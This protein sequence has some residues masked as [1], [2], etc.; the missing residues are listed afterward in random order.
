MQPELSPT[1]R[2]LLAVK[3]LR[4][5][6]AAAES[7]AKEPIAIIGMACRFPG[8]ATT[9]AAFWDLLAAGTD[10]VTE[11][12]AER[13][14]VDAF[15]DPEPGTAGKMYTRYGAFLQHIDQF[16]PHVFNIAPR[17]VA[18]MDPQHRLLLETAWEAL[19][20]SGYPPDGLASTPAGVFVGAGAAEY[21]QIGAADPTRIDPYLTLGST[22]SAAAGRISYVLGLQGPSMLVDTACSSSL[23]AVH[24]ACASLRAGDCA[25]AIAGAVNLM[26]SPNSTIALSSL[27]MMAPDGRCKTFDAA[28]DGFVRGE[29]CGIVVL[30]RLTQALRDGDRVLAVIRGSA[31]NQD[32]RSGGFTAPNGLAQQALIRRALANASVMP[33]EVSYVECHGTGTSLGDPVELHALSAVLG[34]GRPAERPLLVG[35]V[36]T[37]VGHL[38]AAAGMAGLIKTVLALGHRQIT[39]HLHLKTPNPYIA[40]SS[41]PVAV[42]R[43]LMAWE[44]AKLRIAGVSSFGATGTNA[45]VIV[46]EAPAVQ[47]CR[48]VPDR[49]VHILT[50][51]GKSEAALSASRSRM[52]EHLAA[53]ID[54]FADICHT[55]STGRSHFAHRI[56]VTAADAAQACEKLAAAT[57]AHRTAAPRIAFLF[58]G[59]GS[60]Y[61]GMGR[62]LGDIDLPDPEQTRY[63]QPAL[64]KLEYRLAQLWRSWGI[65]PAF[66]LGHSVGEYAAAAVAGLFSYEEGLRLITRRAELM[67]NLPAGGAMLAV[68]CSE[69]QAAEFLSARVSLAAVNGPRSIVLSGDADALDRVHFQCERLKVSHA[70]HSSRMDPILP[71]LENAVAGVAFQASRIPLVSNLTGRVATDGELSAPAYWSRHARHTV[72]FMD[73]IQTLQAEGCE[74]YIEIGP[75]PVLLGMA[76]AQLDEAALALPSLRRNRDDWEQLLESLAALYTAGASVDW[77]AFDAPY[78]R[79]R[80]SLPTYPFQ[81]QRYWLD[82]AP[83][84]ANAAGGRPLLGRSLRSPELQSQVFETEWS[85]ASPAFLAEH[86]LFGEAVAPAAAWLAMIAAAGHRCMGNVLLHQPL[87]LPERGWTQVQT[88]LKQQGFEIYSSVGDSWTLHASGNFAESQ[89]PPHTTLAEAQAACGLPVDTAPHYETLRAAGIELGPGFRQIAELSRGPG[90]AVGR[91][92]PQHELH[93]GVIDACLQML[94]A[95]A[96]DSLTADSLFAP[97]AIE[98][99]E[100]PAVAPSWCCALLRPS[101]ANEIA[102]DLTLFGEDGAPVGFIEGLRL[103]RASRTAFLRA[104]G[105]LYEIAWK[106]AGAG[107]PA[108]AS[109]RKFDQALLQSLQSRPPAGHL[110]LIASTLEDAPLRGLAATLSLEYPD[111]RT[112]CIDTDDPAAPAFHVSAGEDRI[113]I[114]NRQAF[115]PRLARLS[116]R[117]AKAPPISPD[118]TYLITGG[119]GA[120]GLHT[121]RWLVRHG[122]RHLVLTGRRASASL[123]EFDGLD[124]RYVSADV[125]NAADVSRLFAEIAAT[126][127]PLRGILH[128]AGLLD[129][130]VLAQQTW[131]RFLRVM[132]PKVAGSWNLHEASQGLPLDFFVLYSSLAGLLGSPG[133]ANYAAAN[134]YMDALAHHRRELG[135]PALSINWGPWAEAGMAAGA[136]TGRRLRTAG[137]RA[138]PP[139]A[140]LAALELALSRDLAQVVIVDADWSAMRSRKTPAILADL[141][142]AESTPAAEGAF[143]RQLRDAN[144]ARRTGLLRDYVRA[145]VARV[146]GRDAVFTDTEKFFELGMDSL[147]ALELKNVLQTDLAHRMP[148]TLSFEYPTVASLCVFLS[149]VLELDPP[150]AATAAPSDDPMLAQLEELSEDEAQALLDAKLQA[151]DALEWETRN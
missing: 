87:V 97:V 146:L 114:R 138:M 34:E 38:E 75:H 103:R 5:K 26:L 93:T 61:A 89:S 118:A 137:L 15:Y 18:G 102:G 23:V 107:E 56:A 43:E 143:L 55:A 68:Q 88:V 91:V 4:A 98:R 69:T 13:W 149:G 81:R 31:V 124:V 57:A 17:E 14:D 44:S 133:Q 1:Q 27:R 51:S 21:S 122:A 28:A 96:P 49:P 35:S 136:A 72:R 150:P 115:V 84:R 108:A 148:S 46:E 42:P 111:L 16:D 63:V 66:V 145:Q 12:P 29:G 30:K 22:P 3:D 85:A 78:Q 64:Y 117:P 104:A 94:G 127:P 130:G 67:Q 52:L 119:L 54:S 8:G 86:R 95:A 132:A 139:E 39:P 110:C 65:E 40:W 60:Q 99:L 140:A 2:A 47:D 100:L 7:A 59:Q 79:R 90:I 109:L 24:L 105:L 32:G 74:A 142:P 116:P 121:A 53:T 126:M 125:S 123:A 73:G 70:F 20:D 83:Q 92:R 25:I 9:P 71:A 48:S 101:E 141:I 128:T 58:S 41:L 62:A 6:L 50:L 19:E 82:A 36:K 11:V 45:H 120:L 135:L 129:D 113:A 33:D 10:A 131:D 144:P 151:L 112:T 37:N 76:R 134:S 77:K 80:V 106:P 147:M